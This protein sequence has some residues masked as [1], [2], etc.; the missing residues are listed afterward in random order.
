VKYFGR[1]PAVAC[2]FPA[3]L[4]ARLLGTCRAPPRI[5]DTM[6]PWSEIVAELMDAHR[7]RTGR[8]GISRR[9]HRM[10]GTSRRR[11]ASSAAGADQRRSRGLAAGARSRWGV[12]KIRTASH[13]GID[14]ALRITVAIELFG[15][16]TPVDLDADLVSWVNGA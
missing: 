16:L 2:S 3:R 8:A 13:D 6:R 4:L 1:E 14:A 15:G 11:S 9:W 10:Y 5:C 7:A 12:Q